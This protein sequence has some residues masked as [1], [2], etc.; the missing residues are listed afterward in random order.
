[1]VVSV[2]TFNPS[3]SSSSHFYPTQIKVH[4]KRDAMQVTIR[5]LDH[6]HIT[7]PTSQA[8]YSS[9]ARARHR[10]GWYLFWTNTLRIT[11]IRVTTRHAKYSFYRELFTHRQRPGRSRTKGVQRISTS[12][13][14]FIN[15][16]SSQLQPW[17]LLKLNQKIGAPLSESS[18]WSI[19]G[20]SSSS[21]RETSMGSP[22]S[23][24]ASLSYLS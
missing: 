13:N 22:S 14:H 1:M 8:S 17:T 10:Q 23:S 18:I 7:T 3:S 11:A 2:F 20:S 24:G 16:P 9:A 4:K 6:H 21:H 5:L 12:H 15:A 19:A